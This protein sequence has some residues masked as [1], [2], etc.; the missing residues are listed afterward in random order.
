MQ[1]TDAILQAAG[2][3]FAERGYDCTPIADIANL[4]GVAAGTV[5]YHF[6][7][8][9][10]LLAELAVRHLR[11]LHAC[12]QDQAARGGTGLDSVLFYVDGY[13]RY[14]REHPWESA[15]YMKNFPA[16]KLK[17]SQDLF[18]GIL[19]AERNLHML[20]HCLLILGVND[21]SIESREVAVYARSIQAMLLGGA[22]LAL[23]HNGDA[24]ALA[25]DAARSIRRMLTD[26]TPTG[27]VAVQ[28][29]GA[30]SRI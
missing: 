25:D 4:A 5:I 16:E 12:C 14:L 20:L 3:L 27:P 28:G 6:K 29:E 23:F 7:R 21:G 8:K 24:Q 11:G 30:C 19:A 10:R 2:S 9:E 26:I 22:L 1:T 17:G 13:Y 15:A 18:P